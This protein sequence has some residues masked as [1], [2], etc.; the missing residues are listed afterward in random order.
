MLLGQIDSTTFYTTSSTCIHFCSLN[1]YP[2]NFY[3]Y[4]ST[5]R[6]ARQNGIWSVCY[7]KKCRCRNQS[8]IGM[9]RYP[10]LSCRMQECWCRRQRPRCRCPAMQ[11][12]VQGSKGHIWSIARQHH[13]WDSDNPFPTKP[14]SVDYNLKG[15]SL[16]GS[17]TRKNR[18]NFSVKY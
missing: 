5:Y 7:F 14:L 13:I 16:S 3:Y 2:C 17:P 12:Q 11:S 9:L 4:Y 15:Q 1:F 10:G 6:F 18:N 8:G